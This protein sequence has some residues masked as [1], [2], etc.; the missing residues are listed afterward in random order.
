MLVVAFFNKHFFYVNH[1]MYMLSILTCR[2]LG[3]VACLL[4]P[5]IRTKLRYFTQI[6]LFQ[7]WLKNLKINTHLII[8]QKPYPLPD[9]SAHN[10]TLLQTSSK[11]IPFGIAR[12]YIAYIREYPHS[13]GIS[14]P[15]MAGTER[16]RKNVILQ[17][18]LQ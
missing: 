3:C 11:A 15:K 17:N 8:F 7:T 10:I 4:K 1:T 5:L 2:L 13:G 6:S 18:I 12:T 9:Q 14:I 16:N